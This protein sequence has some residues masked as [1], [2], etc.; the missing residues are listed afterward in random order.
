MCAKTSSKRNRPHRARGWITLLILAL[1][2][3]AIMALSLVL[4]RQLSRRAVPESGTGES[5]Q[6]LLTGGFTVSDPGEAARLYPLDGGVLKVDTHRVSYLNMAG[7]E[8]WGTDI[9]MTSPLCCTGD[10]YALIADL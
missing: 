2:S 6:T 9:A 4:A 7:V 8:Q 1:L 5:V 3:I 10:T